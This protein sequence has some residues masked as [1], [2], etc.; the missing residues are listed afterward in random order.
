MYVTDGDW[1]NDAVVSSLC[2]LVYGKVSEAFDMLMVDSSEKE[3]V[4]ELRV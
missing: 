1:L 4:L 2:V 3:N